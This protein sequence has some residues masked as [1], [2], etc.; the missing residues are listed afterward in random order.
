MLLSV[1]R[2]TDIPAFYSKWFINRLKKGYVLTRN[3]MN[4]A[5]VSRIPLSPEVIDCIVFW[6]KNPI[7]MIDKLSII[8]EMGYKYYF[9]FTFNPYDTKIERN[10]NKS[11][12]LKSF[13][14]LS[15]T[16]GKEKI[17]WRYD[18]I[19]LND[20][21]TID[22]HISMF[23]IMCNHLCKY[24]DVCTISF[25]D[26]Y[27]KLSKAIKDNLIREITQSEMLELAGAFSKI[28]KKYNI[29]L[30]TCSEKIDLSSY[31]IYPSACID[32]NIIEKICGYKIDIKKDKNQRENCGCL[33]SVDI[34]VYN[35]CRNGCVYCYANYSDVF[36]KRN[37]SK[38]SPNS[39]ILIG[40]VGV[41][42]KIT[43]RKIK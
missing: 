1:S 3:P 41:N 25:V 21:L 7:N 31:D 38:H 15:K 10:L 34:G 32:R 14:Q 23:E 5:Q 8:D 19:I 29:E 16:I 6:T 2:R 12:I 33:Q 26:I 20:I 13:I 42:E 11:K 43:L 30:R 35:T 24:T 37:C 18:P 4:Y 36:V 39:D 17:I 9:Q 40:S 27:S 22:Y 28:S